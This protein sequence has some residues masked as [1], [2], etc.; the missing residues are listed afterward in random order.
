MWIYRYV[1][2]QRRRE[3]LLCWF[4]TDVERRGRRNMTRVN[5]NGSFQA[6]GNTGILCSKDDAPMI[7]REYYISV[8]DGRFTLRIKHF[9]VK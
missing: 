5:M 1:L 2:L 7:S 6:N 3:V 8:D 9:G 4:L